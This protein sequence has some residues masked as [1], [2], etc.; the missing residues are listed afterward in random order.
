MYS[1]IIFNQIEATDVQHA[2]YQL[3]RA[4]PNFGDTV[5]NRKNSELAQSSSLIRV[6][7]SKGK[8]GIIAIGQGVGTI[9][10]AIPSMSADYKENSGQAL[11]FSIRNG[12]M[13]LSESPY[14]RPYKVSSLIIGR[15]EQSKHCLELD[16]TERAKLAERVILRGI[17]AQCDLLG[18][19]MPIGAIVG[20]F[21]ETGFSFIKAGKLGRPAITG[22]FKCNLRFS[23]LWNI[24]AMASKGCGAIYNS[25]GRK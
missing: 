20:E 13:E 12:S 19:E 18:I 16:T 24:G 7:T 9:L 17:T 15:P 22:T 21:T 23:G 6:C 5:S 25:Q 4:F 3:L 1:Q 14:L 11:D 10:A 2:R 8:A